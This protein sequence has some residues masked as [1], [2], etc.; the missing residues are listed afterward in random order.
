M[1]IK[2]KRSG[3]SGKV[4]LTTDL[5]LGELGVN[6]W[7]GKLYLR[8]NNGTDAIVEIGPV[9]SVAGRV[10]DV[11]LGI[12][13]VASLQTLLDGKA[14]SSHSHTT[15]QVT[16]LG[17]LATLSAVGTAQIA[18]ANVT[19][20]KLANMANS[21][22]KGRVSAGAGAPE[23]LTVAQVQS[24][25]GISGSSATWT[26]LGTIT[27][28][29]GTALTLS[30][31][32]LANYRE[33]VLV[34]SNVLSPASSTMSLSDGTSDFVLATTNSSGGSPPFNAITR[35]SLDNGVFT[36]VGW[37]NSSGSYGSG[38]VNADTTAGL[39]LAYGYSRYSTSST[40]VSIKN[41]SGF[42]GGSL[43]VYGVK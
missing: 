14:P 11:S 13:D 41:S 30:S 43:T 22:I 10:G 12:A 32:S 23:D 40:S 31:L 17:S 7:D 29:S 25:L 4:P 1:G 15:A 8:K 36:S 19:N 5:E 33:L 37:K 20:A 42:S 6:T 26:S 35:I 39:K 38:L 2:L 27:T 28:S 34:W 21:T 18:D 3:V 16:G 9:K 24:L